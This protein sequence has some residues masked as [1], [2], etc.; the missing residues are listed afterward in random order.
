MLPSVQLESKKG[1]F[2]L[3]SKDLLIIKSGTIESNIILPNTILVACI[4]VSS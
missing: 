3:I 1:H 4:H 2:E